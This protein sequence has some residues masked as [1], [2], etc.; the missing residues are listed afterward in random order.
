MID[1]KTFAESPMGKAVIEL[2]E[3]M[4]KHNIANVSINVIGG[5][6]L[7]MRETRNPNDITDIDYVGETLPADFN[8]LADEIGMKHKLGK[9]W[10]NNDVML[11]GTT[12]EDF[13]VSTGKLHFNDSF[14]VG[15]IKINVL[16]ER[17]VLRMKLIAVD[18][19]ITGAEEGGDFSRKKDLPDV[20]ALMKKQNITCDDIYDNF[21]EFIINDN[22]PKIINA[23]IEGGEN[24]IEEEIKKLSKPQTGKTNASA[25]YVRSAN[26]QNMLDSLFDKNNSE[27]SSFSL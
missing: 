23:Y 16:D 19:S 25:T 4:E 3:E 21:G 9:G 15:R 7:M 1:E 27:S 18:T 12:F 24:K 10:I 11:A 8:K 5:F 13:E 2:S 22:L 20:V 26:M 17:D 6:A 14:D